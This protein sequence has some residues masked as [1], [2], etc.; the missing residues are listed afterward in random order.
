MLEVALSK[1]SPSNIDIEYKIED[2][3]KL[4]FNDNV[5]DTVVDTFG[6]ECYVNPKKA[7]QEMK[8]VIYFQQIDL[9]QK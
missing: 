4:S 1:I 5:F 7:L 2:V 6:L 8:R 9:I 3:E